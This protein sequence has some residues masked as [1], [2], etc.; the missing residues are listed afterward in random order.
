M[1][2]IAWVAKTAKNIPKR[3]W[4]RRKVSE[5]SVCI[6]NWMKT[7]L[8]LLAFWMWMINEAM[9]KILSVL[10]RKFHLMASMVASSDHFESFHATM[11]SSCKGHP[12]SSSIIPFN[13]FN[14]WSS[15][16]ST[17]WLKWFTAVHACVCVWR[18]NIILSFFWMA[19]F[20]KGKKLQKIVYL[21]VEKK[22]ERKHHMGQWAFRP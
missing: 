13:S 20:S 1:N 15:S 8:T 21:C 19:Q 2:M 3:K 5:V 22:S 16:S 14:P 18:K 11:S 6:G 17:W 12:P 10:F 4:G 9:S 7:F